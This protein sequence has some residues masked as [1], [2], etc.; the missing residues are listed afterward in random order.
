MKGQPNLLRRTKKY[1]ALYDDIND[2]QVDIKDLTYKLF[3][4]KE[5]ARKKI[6]MEI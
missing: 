5:M 1:D 2:K 4:Q 3:P 6:K